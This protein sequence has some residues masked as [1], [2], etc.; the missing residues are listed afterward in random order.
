L[1][2]FITVEPVEKLELI[3]AGVGLGVGVGV[4]VGVGDWAR[5]CDP[6]ATASNKA[7]AKARIRWRPAPVLINRHGD[8]QRMKFNP[9]KERQP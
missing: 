1:P 3:T 9:D 2:R 7:I 5:A 8:E 6:A 4:G